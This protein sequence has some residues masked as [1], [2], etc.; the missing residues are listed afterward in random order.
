MKR[1][2]S[3]LRF[4][5]ACAAMLAAF[6]QG[7]H[8]QEKHSPPSEISKL[9]SI[10]GSFEGDATV[11]EGG[12]TMRGKAYVEQAALTIV[13]PDAYTLTWVSKLDGKKTGGGEEQLHRVTK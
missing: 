4:M 6:V 8:A 1:R 11:T 13:G 2:T 9:G 3:S 12:K 5:A 7:G 10:L